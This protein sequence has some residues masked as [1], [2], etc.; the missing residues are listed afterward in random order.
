MTD[1]AGRTV[2]FTASQ[3]T[4]GLYG[5]ESLTVE[6]GRKMGVTRERVRLIRDKTLRKL[7]RN[8]ISRALVFSFVRRGFWRVHRQ[9][10]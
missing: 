4:A 7:M 1:D 9:F 3:F 5:T 10:P 8:P 2:F 6:V